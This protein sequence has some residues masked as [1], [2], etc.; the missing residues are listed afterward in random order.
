M[1][2]IFWEYLRISKYKYIFKALSFPFYFLLPMC[3]RE[4]FVSLPNPKIPFCLCVHACVLAIS[5]IPEQIRAETLSLVFSIYIICKCYFKP[6]MKI[7]EIICVQGHTKEFQNI[8]DYAWNFLLIYLMYLDCTKY[9]KV[10]VHF[11]GGQKTSNWI[12]YE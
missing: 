12:W 4:S 3:A 11:W 6:F 7:D 10:N 1:A 5:I 9:I 8:M 2:K